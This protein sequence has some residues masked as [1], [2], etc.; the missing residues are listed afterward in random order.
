MALV[1]CVSLCPFSVA[2][3][4]M[5]F[6][7]RFYRVVVRWR[8]RKA[9]SSQTPSN[10]HR[11]RPYKKE[12]SPLLKIHSRP[13]LQIRRCH[14]AWTRRKLQQTSRKR[15]TLPTSPRPSL[16]GSPFPLCCLKPTLRPETRAVRLRSSFSRPAPA[17]MVITQVW[18]I[19]FPLRAA[20]I[21]PPRNN[22][23][24]ANIW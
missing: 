6:W 24:S 10:H 8:W 13:Q 21:H 22:S 3:V 19:F 1:T 12:T 9:S 14:R 4:F 2:H 20:L 18:K 16:C 17:A 15:A 7:F 11:R 5:V 23:V